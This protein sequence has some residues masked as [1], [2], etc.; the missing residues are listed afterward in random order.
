MDASCNSWVN[1]VWSF[2]IQGLEAIVVARVHVF[3]VTTYDFISLAVDSS[4]TSNGCFCCKHIIFVNSS[5]RT[6]ILAIHLK[7]LLC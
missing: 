5:L 3:V 7:N 1:S 2:K 4:S 6:S